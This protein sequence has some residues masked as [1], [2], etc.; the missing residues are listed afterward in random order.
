MNVDLIAGA[1]P[2]V[3]KIAPVHRAL[4]ARGVA[5]R[6]VHT[7]Q[8]YDERMSEVFFRQLGLPAPDLD[9]G[10]GSGS[11]ARQTA[12]IMV[13]YDE[14]LEAGRPDV[15]VVVGDVN[16]TAACTLVASKLGIPVAHVEAGLR[17]GDRGMPE[18]INRVVTDALADLLFVTEP[19]GV[20]NLRHEGVA[21]HRIHL[22]GNVMIDTLVHLRER[23]AA[24]GTVE[25]LGL[26]GAPYAL[27]TFH[28]PANV[29]EAAPARE[30]AA[31][32]AAV[33]GELPLVFP[34][35]PRT[36]QRFDAYGL[37]AAL[38]RNPAVHLLEPQGYLEF[39]HLME[40][41]A[42][43][44]TDSGGIQEETTFLGTPCLTVRDSTERP[45]TVTHGTNELMPLDAARVG[46]RV[47]EILAD[48]REP[49]RVPPLW[50]G[51]AAERVADILLAHV[52]SLD[53]SPVTG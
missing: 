46:A 44:V 40:H 2:N 28:R 17:S 42:V 16:S 30:V 34:V 32:L 39:L 1:R 33:A 7:G 20:D 9:L 18:E 50:D 11:H 19:A 48:G 45:V 12:A 15:V 36:R 41:A 6:L 43:V 8:H 5:P 14:V 31:T 10:V 35:H 3:M 29:D 38:E 23:A 13:A 25:G 4:R 26:A 47:R 49:G 51:A 37:W 27:V 24:T 22:V 21:E 52:G 53:A